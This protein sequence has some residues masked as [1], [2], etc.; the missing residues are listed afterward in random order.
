MT[1]VT[2]LLD[3]L[4]ADERDQVKRDVAQLTKLRGPEP[5]VAYQTRPIAWAHDVLDIPE[6][7]IRWS[8][9][10]GYAFHTWDGTPDPLAVIA[11]ALAAGQDV[12][13]E[14][15][16][17]TGKTF[18]A[19]WLALWFFACWKDA[20]VGTS[21]PKKDSLTKL[22]WKEIGRH[23]PRFKKR[24]PH[25]EK[26]E[27]A[28]RMRPGADNQETW[29][30]VGH[31]TG[32]DAGA[33]SAAGGQ[34]YHAEHMLWITDETPGIHPAAMEAIRNTLGAEHNLQLSLGNPDSQFDELHQFCIR[35][36]VVH[37]IVSA[38]DHPNVV[39]G[40][41]V[42]P[43]AQSRKGVAKIE[44][45]HQRGSTMYDSRV[46]GRSP[47]Q[48]A[49]ALI[50]LAWL[51]EAVQR[52]KARG[53][54]TGLEALG[55]DPSNSENG[56]KA[57]L[58]RF[59]GRRLM[60]LEEFFCPDANK[61]GRDVYDRF[62][63]PEKVSIPVR[64]EHIGVDNVGVGAGTLN[65]LR[66]LA[67]HMVQG[68][69]GGA[70]VV[71]A[72]QRAPDGSDYEWID[73]SNAYRNLR[74]QMYW[75]FREDVRL[76]VVEI[77]SE[78]LELFA[79]LTNIKAIRRG[80]FVIVEAKE[81]IRKRIGHSPN[82][83]DATVYANWVRAREAKVPDAAPDPAMKAQRDPDIGTASHAEWQPQ[84]ELVPRAASSDG[85]ADSQF[86]EDW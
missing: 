4:D 58:A 79:E 73:D 31:V 77:Q 66:R 8:R 52:A 11:E 7:T 24:Y 19:G 27:L 2:E 32:V 44:A 17:G 69:S 21:A 57:A 53:P 1:S 45:K 9:Y 54:A 47:E 38:L 60:P 30:I 14:S 76:G 50:Q 48:S 62:L 71:E 25:A 28:A 22:L 16:T 80:G 65:E 46:R 74:T 49:E 68:L 18:E 33:T 85:G 83:A 59:V 3:Y 82:R 75:Q 13:V 61:F 51:K 81:D 78:D 29:A 42:I 5:D 63:D 20:I 15:G 34:G 64:P 39:L 41:S 40:R 70:S 23:W 56:D 72:T 36:G 26:I 43:G 55:L 37:V 67:G 84:G 86:G 12:G 35:P 10:P 6:E